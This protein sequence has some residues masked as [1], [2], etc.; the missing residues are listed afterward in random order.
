MEGIVLLVNCILDASEAFQKG[1]RIALLP[2]KSH[3][4]TNRP[5][6]RKSELKRSVSGTRNINQDV[7]GGMTLTK[8]LETGFFRQLCRWVTGVSNGGGSG[9]DLIE[10]M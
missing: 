1:S 5:Q 7:N 10:G 6:S 3:F 4:S 8:L 9:I 2:L